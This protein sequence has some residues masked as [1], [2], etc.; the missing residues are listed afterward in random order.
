MFDNQF[1]Q[2]MAIIG[3]CDALRLQHELREK[4]DLERKK[5]KLNG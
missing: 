4:E 5:L 3:N 2:N 1:L